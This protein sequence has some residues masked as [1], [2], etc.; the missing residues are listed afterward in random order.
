M[1]QPE[2]IEIYQQCDIDQNHFKVIVK[3]FTPRRLESKPFDI[4]LNMKRL[5]DCYNITD[6]A[7]KATI[8]LYCKVK[9][10]DVI[11]FYSIYKAIR[12][13]Y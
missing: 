11:K 6:S 5:N 3:E 12:M 13:I 7:Y 4:I 10:E 9:Y 1:E 2:I 8:F